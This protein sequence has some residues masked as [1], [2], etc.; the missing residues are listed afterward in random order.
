MPPSRQQKGE[1]GCNSDV[2]LEWNPS[3][4][5]GK[6]R[7]MSCDVGSFAGELGRSS[8]LVP[9]VGNELPPPLSLLP[10]QDTRQCSLLEGLEVVVTQTAR[11][12]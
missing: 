11:I 9:G 7:A 3:G 12:L 2:T 1:R 6:G 10:S 4:W 5:L 8:L